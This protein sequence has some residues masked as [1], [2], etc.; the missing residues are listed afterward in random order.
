LIGILR[1]TALRWYRLPDDDPFLEASVAPTLRGGDWV[2]LWRLTPP[3]YGD[4]VLCP[5]PDEPSRI[6]I[7]RLLGEEDDTVVVKGDTVTVN[8]NALDVERSCLERDFEVESPNVGNLVEQHCQME[9]AGSATY[10]RGS[11]AGHKLHPLEIKREVADGGVFLVSDN[12]LFPYD[13]RDYGQ[14]D[15]ETCRE[16][17]IFRLVSKDGFFDVDRRLTLIR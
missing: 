5:E 10:M 16:T 1:A 9:V 11:T 3:G 17:V 2:V 12:R 4:L 6:V 8:G 15:R 13:S 7:G 14:V